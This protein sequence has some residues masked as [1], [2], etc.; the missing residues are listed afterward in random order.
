MKILK[1][2]NENAAYHEEAMKLEKEQSTREISCL[3]EDLEA[4]RKRFASFIKEESTAKKR[5]EDHEITLQQEITQLKEKLQRVRQRC[6]G[7]KTCTVLTARAGKGSESS[8][9]R[10]E[11]FLKKVEKERQ[12][13]AA[14]SQLQ[15]RSKLSELQ[16]KFDSRLK[17][18]E[19]L[20]SETVRQEQEGLRLKDVTVL[21][22]RY[23]EK[24]IEQARTEERKA[25]RREIDNLKA[26]YRSNERQTAEDLTQLEKLHSE[27]VHGLEAQVEKIKRKL[28]EAEQ[29]AQ[30]ATEL[31]NKGSVEVRKQ[32][33]EHVKQA[34]TAMKKADH[35]VEELQKAHHEVQECRVRE[36]SYRDQLSKSL[37][38]N[39]VQRAELLEAKKQ[40]TEAAAEAFHYKKM[41][42][43]HHT[44]GSAGS[45]GGKETTSLSWK[46]KS[47]SYVKTTTC[48]K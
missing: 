5:A 44:D 43:D 45:S 29:A 37:E 34:K 3:K 28:S 24:E 15:V 25:K 36:S 20:I 6:I 17:E 2:S 1:A 18:A 26:V 48:Y 38:E 14:Q 47:K 9:D 10:K 12:D 35:L 21:E 31:A 46:T 7:C 13:S 16:L 32:A 41:S 11:D 39:R 23:E 4:E 27:R 40:A 19:L 42:A 8:S 33:A 22:K 30:N